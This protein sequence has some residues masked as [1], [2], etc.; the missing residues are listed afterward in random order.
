MLL[1]DSITTASVSERAWERIEAVEPDCLYTNFLPWQDTS[2]GFLYT[3]LSANVAAHDTALDCLLQEGFD[4]IYERHRKAANHCWERGRDL[5]L[6]LFTNPV[7]P[8]PTV[9][10]FHVPGRAAELQE[11]LNKEY[12]IILATGLGTLADDILRVGYM[13]YQGDIELVEQTMDALA[14]TV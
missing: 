9:S 3:H 1:T 4:T 10:A 7:Q 13:D 5:D 2:D 11:P 12:G 14:E 6:E 8:S